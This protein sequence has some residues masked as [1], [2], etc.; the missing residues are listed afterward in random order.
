MLDY[1]NIGGSHMDNVILANVDIISFN[2]E[3]ETIIEMLA[4]TDLSDTI[5]I[6]LQRNRR[7]NYLSIRRKFVKYSLFLQFI[8]FFCRH[9][10]Y[11]IMLVI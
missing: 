11:R 9:C 10:C 2:I 3:D 7:E 5:W 1:G 4:K 8:V 6:M